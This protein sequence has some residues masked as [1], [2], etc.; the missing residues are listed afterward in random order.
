M[1]TE[2]SFVRANTPRTLLWTRVLGEIAV[3]EGRDVDA[4]S[5]RVEFGPRVYPSGDITEPFAR[6]L[7]GLGRGQSSVP[8][9][10]YA[11]ETAINPVLD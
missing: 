11:P 4:L 1:E 10:S 2:Q 5:G 9:E 3:G 7:A 8:P 6:H